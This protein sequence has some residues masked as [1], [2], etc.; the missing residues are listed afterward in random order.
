MLIADLDRPHQGLLQVD[1]TAMIDLQ[2]SVK[3]PGP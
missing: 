3:A 2:N 1:Q